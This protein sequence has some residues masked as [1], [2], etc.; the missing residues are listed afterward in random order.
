MRLHVAKTQ[1][2]NSIYFSSV[3]GT[4]WTVESASLAGTFVNR[5]AVLKLSQG[6]ILF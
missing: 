1:K 2:N 3:S 4:L 5:L 6:V